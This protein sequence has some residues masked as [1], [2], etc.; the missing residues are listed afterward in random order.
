MLPPGTRRATETE[1]AALAEAARWNRN[2]ITPDSAWVTENEFIVIQL[3]GRELWMTP[4]EW[5]ALT[6]QAAA[7]ERERIR[8]A[9][10]TLRDDPTWQTDRWAY[11]A[12]ARLIGVEMEES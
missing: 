11:I 8:L 6:A 4:A 7:A 9:L 5:D 12:A 2:V 10:L 3:P 1:I